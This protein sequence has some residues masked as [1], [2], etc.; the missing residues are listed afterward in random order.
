MWRR[1]LTLKVKNKE[2]T[3]EYVRPYL[4]NVNTHQVITI[5][6]KAWMDTVG[7]WHVV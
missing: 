1:T 6:H 2:V 7:I 4:I 3:K 5:Q